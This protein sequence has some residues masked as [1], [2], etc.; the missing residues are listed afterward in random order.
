MKTIKYTGLWALATLA[1]VA[2][3][4]AQVPD[5]SGPPKLGPPP[6]LSLPAIQERELANGLRVVLMEKHQVPVVQIG[7]VVMAG[8]AMDPRGKVGLATMTADMMDEGAGSRDALELADAIDYLGARLSVGAGNHTS[9]ISLYTP[10]SKLDDAL[11]IMADV[12]LRPSFPAEELERKRK[13][14]LTTLLQWHDEP[15]AVASVAFNNAIYGDRHPYGTSSIGDEAAIRSLSVA[16]LTEFH[17]GYFHPNNAVLIVVGDVTADQILPKLQQA[18]GAW[19]RGRFSSPSWPDVKQ[20]D[21]R[22]VLLVDKPG[23]AQSEIR[24]GRVGVERKTEDYYALQVMNTILGGSFTSRLNQNLREDKGYTYGA[25]SYFSFRVM[26]G[27]FTASSAVQTDAT[28]KALQEFFREFD[29]IL[30]PIPEDELTRGKNYLA[31]RYPGRFQT[32]AQ[33]AGQL[34]DL[35]VYDLPSDYF[36]QYVDRILAVTQQ[37]VQRVARKYLDPEKVLIIVVGDREKI[38]SGIRALNLG[39]VRLLSIEDVLGKKPVVEGS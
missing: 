38:E 11:P 19:P 37:D 28:D 13:S 5:R 14:R 26:P 31:F 27:P 15:S 33:I 32:V 6:Q 22:E 24:I 10:L 39:R 4:T 30:E 20:V 8:S 23:A 2:P 29:A 12:A 25:G 36:N 1:A 18:F 16:D 17:G 21:R 7:L 34:D 35:F 3:L 9:V